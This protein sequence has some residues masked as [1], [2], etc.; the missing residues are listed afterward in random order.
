MIH[1]E[2]SSIS[3]IV[4]RSIY[5]ASMKAQH[6]RTVNT[7]Q[8]RTS[9]EKFSD[10][11]IGDLAKNVVGEHLTNTFSLPIVNYDEVRT[12][13]FTQPDRYDLQV[14]AVTIEVKSSIEKNLTNI[15]EVWQQRRIIVYADQKIHDFIFQVYFLGESGDLAFCRDVEKMRSEEFQRKY[16]VHTPEEF[17]DLFCEKVVQAHIVGFADRSL[18]E[19]YVREKRFF[20]FKGKTGREIERDYLNLFIRD[21]YPPER[22]ADMV[23]AD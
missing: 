14:D 2:L 21:C 3:E 8:K 17:A 11:F 22:F 1:V 10:L 19:Q 23:H 13:G 7:W 4:K 9:F 18:A 5:S 6:R 12:D 15:D 20:R 16:R